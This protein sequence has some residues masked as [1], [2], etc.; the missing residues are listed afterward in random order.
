MAEP[1]T[2]L[3]APPLSPPPTLDP[4][5]WF[6]GF[7]HSCGRCANMAL[8]VEDT[9]DGK[10][11][12]VSLHKPEVTAWREMTLGASA[13]L[14]PT[15]FKVR[16][17]RVDAYTGRALLVRLTMLLGPVKAVK[18][19][20]AL[21]K[22]RNEVDEVGALR[23]ASASVA[24]LDRRGVVKGLAAVGAGLALAVTATKGASAYSYIDC[25]TNWNPG[26]QSYIVISSQ[27]ANARLC[28]RTSSNNPAFYAQG[29]R[30]YFD[31][32]ANTNTTVVNGNPYW[33]H[34]SGP[35]GYWVAGALL[36]D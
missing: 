5:G 12:V 14:A 24:R 2:S 18:L 23:V 36:S 34:T 20:G 26:Y 9:V 33:F 31:G 35:N 29:T 21:G 1:Q 17:S 28:P 32:S 10:L 7:D 22:L 16:G 15:L 30:I 6:L 25:Q 11:R 3:M 19:A 4:T 13:A 8:R 27:G